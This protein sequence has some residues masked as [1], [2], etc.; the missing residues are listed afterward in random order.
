MRSGSEVEDKVFQAL[1]DPSRRAI[2]EALF[3]GEQPGENG[4][5]S[6]VRSDFERHPRAT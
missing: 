6:R 1:A 4:S 5:R 3:R 2:F